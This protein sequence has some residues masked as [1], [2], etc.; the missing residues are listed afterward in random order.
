[1]ELLATYF[2]GSVD[3]ETRAGDRFTGNSAWRR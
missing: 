1:M 2:T 3:Y